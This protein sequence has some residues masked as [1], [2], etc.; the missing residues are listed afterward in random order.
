MNWLEKNAPR[1]ARVSFFL[2]F[3]FLF[4]GTSLPFQDVPTELQNS[5]VS[6]LLNQIV[7]STLYIASLLALLS[8]KQ[9]ILQL[10]RREKYL[11]LFLF[12]SLA[13]VT[14]SDF[15]IVSFK[16]WVQSLGMVVVFSAALLHREPGRKI[17][18]DLKA[19]LLL[20]VPLSILAVLLVPGATDPGSTA[21]RGLTSQKNTLGQVSLASL[22][23]FTLS[24]REDISWNR[25]A[26]SLCWC[27]S[28][29]LLI[30]SKSTTSLLAAGILLFV[31]MVLR[32]ERTLLR[33]VVGRLLSSLIVL[34][35]FLFPFL[36]LYLEPTVLD[37]FVHAFG[38]DMTFT[39]RVDIWE[40]VFED[41]KRHLFLG[42]GF[43]GYW[44]EGNSRLV[45]LYE[46]LPWV[47]NQA[48]MG[49]LDI[50]NETGIVGLFLVTLMVVHY[51][52]DLLK[53][54]EEPFK[55]FV[56]AALIV[57]LM[58]S[59]LFRLHQANGSLFILSYLA[60]FAGA[61]HRSPSPGEP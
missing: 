43:E 1:L 27:L 57:N 21:W 29:A 12:W 54:G 55:W 58:E 20:Y 41:A 51:L 24:W 15:G 4:F 18:D 35:F 39:S 26:T 11:T 47:I 10:V 40:N 45:L 53:Q 13:T 32:T 48:H 25:V 30:G 9:R 8:E 38:K 61:V 3:F 22:I 56:F 42:C 16:R 5:Q 14:W 60:L 31:A 52:K 2:Y 44:V 6:N 33:P 50:L 49:Y 46:D 37:S 17:L 23:V 28:L 7:F 34:A 59:T 19:V 36:L